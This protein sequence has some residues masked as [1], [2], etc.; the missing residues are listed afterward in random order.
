MSD[1][2]NRWDQAMARALTDDPDHWR[3]RAGEARRAAADMED[4]EA[5]RMMLGI[6]AGYD[7]LAEYAERRLVAGI[8]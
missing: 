7:R 2:E 5:R 4:A 1:R 8:G 3:D 6:A